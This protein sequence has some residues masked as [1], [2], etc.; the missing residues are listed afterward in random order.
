M[1]LST[2]ASLRKQ[3]EDLQRQNADTP[4]WERL[5]KSPHGAFLLDEFKKRREA[6]MA[7]YGMIDARKA[8]ADVALAWVQALQQETE[9]VITRIE[10]A[11]SSRK[12]LD[13]LSKML[14]SEIEKGRIM[15]NAEQS[16]GILPKNMPQSGEAK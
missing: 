15:S 11:E 9:R 1:I 5:A 12:E 3:H 4:K 6:V 2:V 10:N 7:F 13:E 14:E 8:G 16:D